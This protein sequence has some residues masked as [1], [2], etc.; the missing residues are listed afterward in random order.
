MPLLTLFFVR[1]HNNL[2]LLL[3]ESKMNSTVGVVTQQQ[4]FQLL[5]LLLPLLKPRLLTLQ[6]LPTPPML[7]T[8]PLLPTPPRLLTLPLLL[9]PR[10]ESLQILLLLLTLP[11]LLTPPRLLT[12]QLPPTLQPPLNQP[13]TLLTSISSQ[14]QLLTLMIMVLRPLS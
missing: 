9:T 8:L 5:Q 2:Q 13:L 4:I 7:L 10:Q 11:L 1:W 3:I 6:L 14:I 12:L